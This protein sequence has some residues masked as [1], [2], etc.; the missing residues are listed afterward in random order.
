MRDDEQD[1][2][3]EPY[4]SPPTTFGQHAACIS[5]SAYSKPQNFVREAVSLKDVR[6]R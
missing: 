4:K 2:K 5:T 6:I 1:M 3:M